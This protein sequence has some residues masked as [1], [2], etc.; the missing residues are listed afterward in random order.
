MAAVE[1]TLLS[2]VLLADERTL[3]LLVTSLCLVAGLLLAALIVALVNRW[4]Q[5][6]ETKD[7]TSPTAQLAHFRSLYEA[8]TIS[9][10]EF[11]RLR[12]LLGVRLRES[13]GAAPPV[14]PKPVKPTTETGERP[15]DSPDTGIRPA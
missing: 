1:A 3:R 13:L 2:F 5:R 7:E 15:P 6:H 12:T 8:G 10:E 14:S 4:R 11:E 9:L